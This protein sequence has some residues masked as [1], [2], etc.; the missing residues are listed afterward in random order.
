MLI[1][2]KL[3]YRMDEKWPLLFILMLLDNKTQRL[4]Q[5]L[6]IKCNLKLLF[7][8]GCVV[9]L[10]VKPKRPLPIMHSTDHGILVQV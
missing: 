10:N 6:G 7:I 5:M 2:S 4:V 8:G 3:L 1:V 9:K